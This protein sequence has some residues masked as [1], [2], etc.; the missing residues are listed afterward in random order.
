MD[1]IAGGVD[2]LEVWGP[3]W[4]GKIPARYLAGEWL[5]NHE[6]PAAYQRARVVLADHHGDMAEHGFLANRLFDAVA[7]GARVVCD[8]VDGIAETFHGAVQVYDSPEHLAWLVSPEGLR[9]AFP[10]DAHMAEISQEVGQRHSFAA[11]AQTLW[12]DVRAVRREG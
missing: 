6:L 9:E 5:A 3:H 1:A 8:H 11:R 10:D 12:T 7:A 4:P 2:N